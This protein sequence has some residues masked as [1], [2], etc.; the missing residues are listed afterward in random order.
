MAVDS[1]RFLA[2]YQ[3]T[4]DEVNFFET[5]INVSSV[6][7]RFE[8]LLVIWL[9]FRSRKKIKLSIEPR[10]TKLILNEKQDYSSLTVRGRKIGII[11]SDD[12]LEFSL[13][14][15]D[16]RILSRAR[17]FL[18]SCTFYRYLKGI[19]GEVEKYR[20]S[21]ENYGADGSVED[22]QV[23]SSEQPFFFFTHLGKSSRCLRRF[24][25]RRLPYGIFISRGGRERRASSRVVD[26]KRLK[27]EK[28]EAFRIQSGLIHRLTRNERRKESGGEEREFGP[29]FVRSHRVF[30]GRAAYI[31]IPR[32]PPKAKRVD[33]A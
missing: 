13:N 31:S 25:V 14:S 9:K 33:V 12:N 16:R 3:E 20:L 17:I 7:P 4:I 22:F 5:T 8:S 26:D 30:R 11:E 27:R 19:L 24:V 21:C 10:K 15:P 28:G 6:Q 32:P 29:V 23:R 1:S 2:L 18:P